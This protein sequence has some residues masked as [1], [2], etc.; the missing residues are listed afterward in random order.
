VFYLF[1]VVVGI[2][3]VGLYVTLF[4]REV[5]GFAEQRLGKLEALPPDLG[6]WKSDEDS[7]EAKAA[8]RDGMVR[9]IRYW[10]D[11]EK[12]RLLFQARYRDA[13]S[14]E[15][16]RADDDVVVKRKRIRS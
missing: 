2:V 6:K 11:S 16:V 3:G 12:D 1:L 15:I 10:H 7:D 14:R 8:G 9:E 13:K 4:F 5:P